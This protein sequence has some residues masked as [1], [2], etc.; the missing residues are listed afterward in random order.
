VDSSRANVSGGVLSG[1]CTSYANSNI[2]ATKFALIRLFSHVS[3]QQ[4]LLEP[5]RSADSWCFFSSFRRHGLSP[6]QFHTLYTL[7]TP[8]LRRHP[9]SI[10]LLSA[11]ETEIRHKPQE[12]SQTSDHKNDA[13]TSAT[14]EDASKDKID[15]GVGAKVEVSFDKKKQEGV[16][17]ERMYGDAY[18][19]GTAS[20]TSRPSVIC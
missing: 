12:M 4:S 11:V 16:E 20:Y 5:I 8:P 13:V 6:L 9:A 18:V 14:I 1:A 19:D 3:P 17:T 10:P 2:Y 7:I 15:A